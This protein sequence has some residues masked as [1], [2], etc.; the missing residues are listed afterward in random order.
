VIT[1]EE[2]WERRGEMLMEMMHDRDP[3]STAG[4][5][6]I[7]AHDATRVRLPNVRPTLKGLLRGNASDRSLSDMRPRSTPREMR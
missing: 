1:V 7:L 2:W 4:I 3:L 5:V 6:G